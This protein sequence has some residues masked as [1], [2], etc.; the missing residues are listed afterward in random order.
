MTIEHHEERR[1]GVGGEWECDAGAILV[2]LG[3]VVLDAMAREHAALSY[4]IRKTR[5]VVVNV[6][7]VPVSDRAA[8]SAAAEA[9]HHGGLPQ[10]PQF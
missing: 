9:V 2:H 5:R 1:V 10:R 8:V 4:E 6:L 3:L 7:I